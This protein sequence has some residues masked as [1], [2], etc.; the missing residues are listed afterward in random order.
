MD[1]QKVLGFPLDQVR[2]DPDG[3]STPPEVSPL[4]PPTKP[5]QQAPEQGRQFQA[6]RIV[7]L[8][9]PPPP[10]PPPLAPAPPASLALPEPSAQRPRPAIA[11]A[12]AVAVAAAPSAVVA[13]TR[14]FPSADA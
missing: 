4:A 14:N 9:A 12:P 13:Q 6:T 8:E 2:L 11:P 10:P 3:T 7:G 5:R 1:L